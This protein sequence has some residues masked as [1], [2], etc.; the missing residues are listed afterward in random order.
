M[1]R[2]V[3]EYAATLPD[4]VYVERN[5]FSCSQDTQEMITK[6]IQEQNLNRIVIAACTPRTH[7]PLFRETLKAAGL[8]EYLV[9][10]ANIRNHNSWV[11]TQQ[12]A[13]G[14]SQGQRS[15]ADGCCQGDLSAIP[16]NLS[17]VPITQKAL[18]IGGGVAGM[19]SALNLAEQGF[20]VHLVEKNRYPWWQ[21]PQSQTY[22]VR[23]ACA[24]PG[25]QTG[26]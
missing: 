12:S 26:G 13:G 24:D 15:G 17:A 14:N 1:S 3:E 2:R 10:M 16:S 25:G 5:L 8:N 9:E 22:L 23:G 4:V 6:R 11:H 20:E 19:T 18:V 7:E 21:C